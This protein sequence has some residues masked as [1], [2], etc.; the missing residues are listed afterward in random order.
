MVEC[1]TSSIIIGN[2]CD[3]RDEDRLPGAIINGEHS[4]TDAPG[5]ESRC[6][7]GGEGMTLLRDGS[8]IMVLF[9]HDQI[10]HHL[11]SSEK[12]NLNSSENKTNE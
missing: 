5:R 10:H 8:K 3:S 1:T 12:Q 11:T 9:Q 6:E 7:G 2:G 4:S